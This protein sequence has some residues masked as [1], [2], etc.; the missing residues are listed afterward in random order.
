MSRPV[1]PDKTIQVDDALL[2]SIARSIPNHAHYPALMN[3]L[4][5]LNREKRRGWPVGL[6]RSMYDQ[7]VFGVPSNED[8]AGLG[9][10]FGLL[11][12]HGQSKRKTT[13]RPDSELAA[14]FLW[15]NVSKIDVAVLQRANKILGGNG[16]VRNFDQYTARYITGQRIRFIPPEQVCHSLAVLT[17]R[18]ENGCS[19]LHPVV[20]ATT[21]MQSLFLIHPFRDGNGRLGRLLFQWCLWKRMSLRYPLVPLLPYF[22]YRKPG[23]INALLELDL[24]ANP[25]PLYHQYIVEALHATID[26]VSQLLAKP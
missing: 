5:G 21:V 8:N 15:H 12:R 26:K 22:E 25:Y 1:G 9:A 3:R 11:F 13:D 4:A 7:E 20:F 6:E 2:W 19:A 16:E 23:L 10:Q 14:H 18:M 24:N 17:A